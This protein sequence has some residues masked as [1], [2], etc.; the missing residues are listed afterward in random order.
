MP[1][2]LP[3]FLDL[4]RVTRQPL[5]LAGRVRIKAMPRLRALLSGEAGDAEL[6]LRAVDEGNGRVS[7]RGGIEAQLAL[8]CQRCL[9]PMTQ[10]VSAEFRLI[11]VRRDSEAAALETEEPL[12]SPDGRV[13]LAELVEDELL[14]TAPAVPMHENMRCKAGRQEQVS[15]SGE[16][17]PAVAQKQNPFAVLE[18]LKRHR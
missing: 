17:H 15:R 5:E 18:Q 2:G 6:H 12:L 3:E 14:L 7:L 1:N 8:T 4:A 10:P 13:N 11:W 16:P 9:E